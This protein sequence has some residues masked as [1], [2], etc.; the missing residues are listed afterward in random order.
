MV[1]EKKYMDKEHEK[2]MMNKLSK[3]FYK[4]FWLSIIIFTLS[5]IIM[6][7]LLVIE[8]IRTFEVEDSLLIF[9]Y[10]LILVS[11]AIGAII[12]TKPFF[13]DLKY[14]KSHEPKKIVGEVVKYRR[15]VHGGDPDTINH[16]PTI[17]DINKEWIEVEV[18]ADNTEL[19][20]VY[21]C[22]YL[23]NTKLAIC[24]ELLNLNEVNEKK[25]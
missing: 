24:E 23:P 12:D 11:L 19:N 6:S 7:I 14:I 13:K 9:I 4:K 25:V 15:V 8:F 3:V 16:Y 17:K 5:I 18:K 2:T 10:L 1:W 20:R 21:H 22:I